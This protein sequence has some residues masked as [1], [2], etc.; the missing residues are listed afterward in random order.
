M[1]WVRQAPGKGLEWV[2]SIDS[3]G[4]T[5]YAPS[6]PSRLSPST[7]LL[8]LLAALPGLRAA[9]ELVESGG[10]LQTPGGSLTL[11]C[12]AS[13]FTF[14]SYGMNWVR[15]A[16]GKGLEFVAGITS[17]GSSTGYASSVK[18]RFTISRDNSQSTVTLQMNSL[19]AEDTATY[20]CAKAYG[21]GSAGDAYGGCGT[22][23]GPIRAHPSSA[24]STLL[25]LLLAALPGLRAAVELVE[26]GGGLQT[27]GGSLTLRCKASGFTFSSFQMGWVRQA[28][29]KGLEYVAGITSSGS[30]TSYA[31]SVKGRF[32]ISRDN[33]QSTLT[34]QM[35]S[36]R[37]EDTATY[38]CAKNAGFG[39]TAPHRHLMTRPPTTAP[40]VLIV[41]VVVAPT[42][43]P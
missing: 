40:K 15:Q 28:P 30:Y 9:V 10:G 34:L 35:N 4:S 23:P 38:Y 2:V 21:S 3:D 11:C 43:A 12:K 22:D 18:G 24:P 16:P 6:D 36:L 29:G 8:L 27:P 32:T 25:L 26:S 1:H 19:R 39:V 42:P 14:S 7:L 13:G 33:S 31:P 20:Y 5:Y 17:S 41:V 37:A